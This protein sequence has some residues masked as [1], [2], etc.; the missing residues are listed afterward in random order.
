MKQIT[1]S[2]TYMIKSTQLAILLALIAPWEI[3]IEQ[4]VLILDFQQMMKNN[5]NM[6]SCVY[7]I[8]LLNHGKQMVTPFII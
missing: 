3:K 4:M 7:K 1:I 2:N 8:H 6:I 5:D